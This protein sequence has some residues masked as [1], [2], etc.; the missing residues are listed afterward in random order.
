M[1]QVQYQVDLPAQATEIGTGCAVA[2][3]LLDYLSKS[4]SSHSD[5]Q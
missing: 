4:R 5:A 1:P 2:L 3:L